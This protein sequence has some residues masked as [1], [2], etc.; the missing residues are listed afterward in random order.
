MK[1]VFEELEAE[2][3]QNIVDWKH[4]EIERK[5]L[6]IANDNL[7]VECMSKEVFYVATNYELNVSRFT[8]MH[9]AHTII[10]ARC[11]ELKAELS[12]LR[13][14][15]HNDNHNELVNR[16]S[17]L[18]HYKEL[19]D[20]I[21]ITRAK[22]IEQAT[23]L[24][25]KNVNLKAQILNN[26]NSVSKDHA[27]PTVLALGK[28]AIDVEPIPSRLRNNREAHLG[29][30]RHLKES[31]KTICEIVEEAK[32]FDYKPSEL[33]VDLQEDLLEIDLREMGAQYGEVQQQLVK[34]LVE[35]NCCGI[36][37]E[38]ACTKWK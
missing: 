29:Y 3:A 14:K 34:L 10:E 15:I 35:E 17:N 38:C 21:K 27:N 30:L 18:E 8:K 20:S 16:F 32:V 5:N 11:L 23:A 12:N 36:E 25:T 33:L 28:Y 37:I 7:I 13:D 22:H 2:V 24:T 9:V 31:V 6:L 4:D 1:D 26:V 19:Y